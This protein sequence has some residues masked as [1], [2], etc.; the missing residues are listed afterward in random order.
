MSFSLTWQESV[1]RSGKDVKEDSQELGKTQELP[2]KLR[3]DSY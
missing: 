3:N 1:M 2:N